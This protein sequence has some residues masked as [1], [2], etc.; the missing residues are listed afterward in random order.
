MKKYLPVIV[1]T[2]IMP[3]FL[4]CGT[5]EKK[6]DDKKIELRKEKSNFVDVTLL[7]KAAEKE[8]ESFSMALKASLREALRNG[9]V[10][11]MNVCSDLAPE[12]A[13]QHSGQGIYISRITERSRNKNNQAD[14]TH[15]SILDQFADKKTAPPFIGEWRQSGGK[16]FY[17]Y[18]KPIYT[19][20]ICLKCHGDKSKFANGLIKRLDG[21]YPHDAATGYKIGD[22]RGMFEIEIELPKARDFVNG[23]S[24]DSI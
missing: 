4:S 9:P 10:D 14:S 24:P 11:A 18:Y 20:E 3:L 8:I 5:G 7:E 6:T 16:S 19:Q 17:Y 15:L 13:M 2:L 21:R 1:F 12:I 23:F 22:L